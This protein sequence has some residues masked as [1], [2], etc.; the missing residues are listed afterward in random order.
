MLGRMERERR[1]LVSG[2]SRLLSVTHRA[3][4]LTTAASRLV[5]GVALG[6]LTDHELSDLTS[7]RFAR[8]KPTAD[9]LHPWEGPWLERDL[10]PAPARVLVGGAGRGREVR[11]LEARGYEV[12]AFD[13]AHEPRDGV[14]RLGYED[15]SSDDPGP[16]AAAVAAIRAAAPFDA[17]LLGWTSF[18][19]LP[20]EARR[21][22]TLKALRELGDGP[23]LLSYWHRDGDRLG[24]GRASR[25]GRR[26]G[27]LVPGARVPER[28]ADRVVTQAGYAHLFSDDELDALAAAAGYR[29]A[30]SLEG[31][32]HAT[33]TPL[34]P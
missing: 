2:M 34:D 7:D 18:T 28:A 17:V 1:W 9:R 3:S 22:A 27:R 23:L 8:G 4:Q 13:P 11:W 21:L 20:G 6:A 16:R 12:V 25:I 31:F 26:I 24:V 32:P 33:L 29:C 5:E 10:P 15:L 30:R 14:L 19:H